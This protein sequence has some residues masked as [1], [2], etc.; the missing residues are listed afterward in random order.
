[1]FRSVKPEG[2]VPS[3]K[4]GCFT[5]LVVAPEYGLKHNPLQSMVSF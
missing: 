4:R 3:C 5:Y 1:M 2:L